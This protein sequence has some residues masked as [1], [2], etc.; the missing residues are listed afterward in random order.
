MSIRPLLLPLDPCPV[1]PLVSASKRGHVL[2][3]GSSVR[4]PAYDTSRAMRIGGVLIPA[5][6][7]LLILLC[8]VYAFCHKAFYGEV[9]G[10]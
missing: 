5:G 2:P 6:L 4:S 7:L 3:R 8:C 1:C 10:L 9:W